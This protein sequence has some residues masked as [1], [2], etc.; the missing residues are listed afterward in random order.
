M[1]AQSNDRDLSR[2]T[3]TTLKARVQARAR[4]IR[5]VSENESSSTKPPTNEFAGSERRLIIRLEDYWLS[6]RRCVQG[7]FFEDFRPLRN[8]VPWQSCFIAY[9][10]GEDA[11]PVFDHVG[12]SIIVL[13]RPDRTN[14]PDREW[15]IDAVTLRFGKMTEALMTCRPVKREGCFDGPNGIV[16]LYRSLL[17]PFVDSKRAPKYVMGAMTYRLQASR[18]AWAERAH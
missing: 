12:A 3:G 13:L 15:L 18:A 11:E 10:H 4:A 16:V 6:L 5:L 9:L 1:I 17:L 8:P 2:L 7:T 14:L